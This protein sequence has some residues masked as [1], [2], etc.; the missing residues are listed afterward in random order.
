MSASALVTLGCVVVLVGL[1]SW[2]FYAG[3]G[4]AARHDGET[5]VILRQ[6]AGLPEIASSLGRADVVR[7]A[8][9][10]M[11]ATQIT[12]AA[13]RLKAGEY[14]F[15]SEA[16]MA[17]VIDKIRRGDVVHHTVTIAEGLTSEQVVDVLMGD[18]VLTGAAPV[19]SEGSVLPETYE[20]RRGEDRA[21]V[22]RRM[23]D[24]RDTLL[25]TLWAQR[26]SD[27]PL[28]TPE[29]AVTLASLV[30]KETGVPSERPR[31][32]AV[33]INR[34]QK[35]IRLGSDP[36]TIYGLTGGR[37]L[38][39]GIRQSELTTYTPYNTYMID[40]LPPG[41]ICNPGRASL[42]AALDPPHTDELYFVASGNGGHVFASTLEEH[43]KNVEHWR[44]VERQAKLTAIAQGHH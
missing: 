25:R 27:L 15:A 12:G 30:E 11:A 14:E 28:Q 5:T 32:A 4:P 7:S 2:W 16:S 8:A 19:P 1:V 29:Q 24:A 43:Q 35:G 22:L 37:P 6:G 26:R 31:V 20:V 21:E 36:T 40:G 38:G 10:F 33:F 9:V 17:A 23:M 34:L 18:D 13:R 39:R 3:P 44:G 42:A 41:P